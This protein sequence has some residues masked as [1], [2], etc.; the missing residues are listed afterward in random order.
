M[1]P[2]GPIA[3]VW[4]A[5]AEIAL[6]DFVAR[7]RSAEKFMALCRQCPNYNRNWACPPFDRSA[8]DFLKPGDVVYLLGLKVVHRAP[9]PP[10]DSYQKA[11]AYV[12]KIFKTVKNITETTLGEIEADYPAAAAVSAG[13]CVFC[14]KCARIDDEPCRYPDKPR[15]SLEALGFDI[16]KIAEEMLKIKLLWIKDKLPE[17]NTFINAIFYSHLNNSLLLDINKRLNEI[18]IKLL[19]TLLP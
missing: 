3:E 15:R 10:L 16:T 2:V 1:A 4:P 19:A 8:E 5:S 13:G 11:L 18:K 9:S 17:Y 6:D 7:Y 12:Q 14:P